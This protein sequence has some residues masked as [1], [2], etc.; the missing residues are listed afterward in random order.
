MSRTPDQPTNTDARPDA[1]GRAGRGRVAPVEGG[2]RAV[3]QAVLHAF[4]A[5]APPAERALDEAAAPFGVSGTEVLA[6][7]HAEDFLRL[8]QA[9]AI[10][11]AYPFS[12]V[13]TAHRVR[14]DGGAEVYSMCAID[15]LG[16]ASMLDRDTVIRSEDPQ[17]G[18]SITI[19]VAGD[20]ATTW[21]PAT[22]VVMAGR[23]DGQ[24][25]S[26]CCEPVFEAAADVCCEQINFFETPETAAAWA[27]A[28][29]Q[30]T[31]Q[32]RDQAGA[33]AS[34]VAI[35]GRLLNES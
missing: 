14:I 19:Q 7:L 29:P 20:G 16:I 27:L 25:D 11:A 26:E 15:A 28:H 34:G 31:G 3:H 32:I 35:F 22:A 2:M 30:V 4:A 13:P 33:H 1:V 8:D 6:Q 23:V 18:A 10:Q 21:Q 17:T 9:G 5:G 24:S 12:A